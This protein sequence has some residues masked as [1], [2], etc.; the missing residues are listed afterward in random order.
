MQ[1]MPTPNNLDQEYYPP[2]PLPLAGARFG[3]PSMYIIDGTNTDPGYHVNNVSVR[4]THCKHVTVE[5]TLSLQDAAMD[6]ILFIP[7]DFDPAIANVTPTSPTTMYNANSFMNTAFV[8]E[9]KLKVDPYATTDGMADAAM[10]KSAVEPDDKDLTPA[11]TR[12]K[13]QNRAA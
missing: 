12:R 1:K 5:L 9:G 11:Q 6:P 7:N 8:P 13:A 2:T 10:S 4:R 3:N